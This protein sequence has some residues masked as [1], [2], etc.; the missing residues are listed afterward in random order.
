MLYV[1]RCRSCECDVLLSPSP[2]TVIQRNL[3][4][5]KGDIEV[6]FHVSYYDWGKENRSLYR[7]VRSLYRGSSVVNFFK[8]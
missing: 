8:M 6:L 2:S 4:L 1:N 3:D 7:G 5:T